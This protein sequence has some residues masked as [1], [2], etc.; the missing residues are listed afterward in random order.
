MANN[1]L[2]NKMTKP[3]LNKP[4]KAVIIT[5]D[6][7]QKHVFGYGYPSLPRM[8]VQEFYDS[9]VQDGT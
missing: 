3:V 1:E 7:V 4:L 6:E 2:E 9:R 8:S 5:K